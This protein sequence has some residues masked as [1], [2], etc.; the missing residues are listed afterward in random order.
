M[1]NKN[2][3]R[4]KKVGCFHSIQHFNQLFFAAYVSVIPQEEKRSIKN[5]L[6]M[7]H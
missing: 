3:K 6:Q 4:T 7:N 1:P 5:C 2:I